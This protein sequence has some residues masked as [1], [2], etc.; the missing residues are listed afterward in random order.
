MDIDTATM[1]LCRN[2]RSIIAITISILC[3]SRILVSYNV[4]EATDEIRVVVR[5][6]GSKS[7]NNGI[8]STIER[9]VFG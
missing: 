9:V 2:L 4:G 6:N 1:H 5:I 8:A 3:S 7:N